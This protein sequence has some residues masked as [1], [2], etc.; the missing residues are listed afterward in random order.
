MYGCNFYLENRNRKKRLGKKG[1]PCMKRDSGVIGQVMPSGVINTY[2][3]P[4]HS[5]NVLP[6]GTTPEGSLP[7][8]IALGSDGNM[9]FAETS[10]PTQRIGM[11]IAPTPP[12]TTPTINEYTV[13]GNVG[14]VLSPYIAVG[15]DGNMWFSVLD[16]EVGYITPAGEIALSTVPTADAWPSNLTTGPD[17]RM[18]FT[19]PANLAANGKVGA[20]SIT[21]PTAPNDNFIY[22]TALGGTAGFLFT[23]NVNASAAPAEPVTSGNTPK[24]TLWWSWTAPTNLP[25]NT[26]LVIRTNGSSYGTV[27]GIYTGSQ[28][29]DLQSVAS[30][31]SALIGAGVTTTACT[32]MPVQAGMSYAIVV[33]GYNGATGVLLM[34]WRLETS[35]PM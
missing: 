13:P 17:G 8:A 28:L 22:A 1:R 12:Q 25:A 3:L 6:D 32:P 29:A 27:V 26:Y 23:N 15:V 33:D 11:I 9:W 5:D 4:V 19:E 34:D 7:S 10:Q 21:V 2:Q 30:S 35:C 24:K 20:V 18:W 16:D 31:S 14:Y